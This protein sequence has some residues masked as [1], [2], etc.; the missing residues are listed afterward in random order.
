[1]SVPFLCKVWE[2]LRVSFAHLIFS[3][4]VANRKNKSS[5]VFLLVTRP[6]FN[7]SFLSYWQ[8]TGFSVGMPSCFGLILHV[9]MVLN[10]IL[11]DILVIDFVPTELPLFE[12]P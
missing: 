3:S 1:M 9:A 11:F 12:P 5:V 2:G 7:I 8:L 4:S 6:R 10:H